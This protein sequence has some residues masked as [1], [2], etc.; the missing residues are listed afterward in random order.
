LVVEEWL[1]G[2]DVGGGI[3]GGHCEGRSVVRVKYS[4]YVRSIY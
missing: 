1:G 4:C 3:G 2:G